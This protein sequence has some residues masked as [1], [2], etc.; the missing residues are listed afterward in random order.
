MRA[1]PLRHPMP[2][3]WPSERLFGHRFPHIF[4]GA[5][6][7]GDQGTTHVRCRGPEENTLDLLFSTRRMTNGLCSRELGVR[8]AILAQVISC[9]RRPLLQRS[10]PGFLF[11]P[12]LAPD[13]F[14]D[15]VQN[16]KF[17]SWSKGLRHRLYVK[18]ASRQRKLQRMQS[19]DRE[20][21]SGDCN[22]LGA[23][24]EACA[25]CAGSDQQSLK[26][27]SS[28]R[29]RSCQGRGKACQARSRGTPQLFLRKSQFKQGSMLWS[30]SAMHCVLPFCPDSKR[31]SRNLDSCFFSDVQPIPTSDV[32]D[33]A[34]WL[35]QRNCELRNAIKHGDPVFVAKLAV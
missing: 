8:K 26:A 19:G 5:I 4:H 12:P 3:N 28:V 10:S 14:E 32:Q 25:E 22:F 21:E 1:E 11:F 24:Q 23:C 2:R 30:R 9:F 27:E 6:W 16:P 18:S 34:A 29:G 7:F 15:L 20:V 31:S 17:G 35:S 33:L 13:W